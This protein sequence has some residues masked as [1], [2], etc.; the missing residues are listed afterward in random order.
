M[1]VL[2]IEPQIVNLAVHWLKKLFNELTVAKIELLKLFSIFLLLLTK[3][4]KKK[5]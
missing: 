3:S 4:C 2:T 5:S 1:V